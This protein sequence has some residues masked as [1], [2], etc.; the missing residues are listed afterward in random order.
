MAD[1]NAQ[2]NQSS[3]EK[4]ELSKAEVEALRSKAAKA[5]VY[6]KLESRVKEI[7]FDGTVEE[8]VDG[9]EE[10]YTQEVQKNKGGEK[11]PEKPPEKPVEKTV[12]AKE[13]ARA[14]A[15]LEVVLDSK[16]GSDLALFQIAQSKMKDDEQSLWTPDE[17][18]KTIQNPGT[19]Q[20]IMSMLPQ[21]GNNLFAAAD[22]YLTNTKGKA[23]M[24]ERAEKLAEAKARVGGGSAVDTGGRAAGDKPLTIQ[25]WNDKERSKIA[26]KDTYVFPG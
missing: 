12:D 17:L 11:P 19:R 2:G 3:D 21:H 5:E 16:L 26:P 24:M 20:I 18:K 4:V 9:L 22:E 8:Y 13:D 6:E 25:E 23:K 15:T 1:D 10:A 7:D 14:K